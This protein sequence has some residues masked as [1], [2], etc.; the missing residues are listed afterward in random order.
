MRGWWACTRP[1]AVHI[2]PLK[3]LGND[4]ATSSAFSRNP[5]AALRCLWFQGNDPLTPR[6]LSPKGERGNVQT[7]VRGRCPR[8]LYC[9]PAGQNLGQRE[10][11]WLAPL[12]GVFFPRGYYIV[13]LR[14]KTSVG[15]AD[16][17]PVAIPVNPRRGFI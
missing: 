14:G 17:A 12:S 6:P 2:P 8:L 16:I 1:F 11:E 15:R 13:P 9:A 4:H 10:G 3:A 7:R 5:G